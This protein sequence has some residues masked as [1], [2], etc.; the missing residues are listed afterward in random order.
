MPS[1]KAATPW[2]PALSPKSWRSGAK[3]ELIIRGYPSR[4]R[5]ADWQ[6]A[7]T[8]PKEELP[9]LTEIQRERARTLRVPDQAYAIA[10]KAG[11]L[12]RKRLEGEMERVEGLIASAA[13]RRG[14]E[15]TVVIWD[16]VESQFKFLARQNGREREHT[17][18][19]AIVDDLLL[20]KEGADRRLKEEVDFLLGGWA[21]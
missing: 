5:F 3:M 19:G 20:G 4:I 1:A 16:F 15:V 21:E 14:A 8:L 10:L 17:I 11:E 9:R 12:A 7:N 18:P 6:K 13:K 2:V